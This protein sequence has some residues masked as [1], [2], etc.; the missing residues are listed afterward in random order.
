MPTRLHIFDFDGTLFRSPEKPE[1]WVR[2]WW[3]DPKSLA[4]PCVPER[5]GA[6]WWSASVVSAAK[7]S[8]A[9]RNALTALVT[10]RL[11][12]RFQDRVEELLGYAGLRFD[13]VRL[14]PG[15]GSTEGKKIRVFESLLTPEIVEVEM[16]EDRPEHVGIFSDFFSSKGVSVKMNLVQRVTNEPLCVPTEEIART[17]LRRLLPS[18]TEGT[19]E[20]DVLMRFLSKETKRLGV[21]QHVYVVGG[22]VRNFVM[23]LPPKDIDVVIDALALKGKNAEW[24]ANQLA[25]SIPAQ[26]V[27][28]VNQYGVAILTVKGQ[29]ELNGVDMQGQTIDIATAR[30]E[31]Y[32]GEAGKGYKPSDVSSASIEVDLSRREFTFNTL[33]WR[34]LDLESGPGKAEVIDLTGLGKKDLEQRLLRTP[35]DPDQTFS[36]DPTRMLRAI[37]FVAKYGFRIDD[38]VQTSIRKNADKLR[39]MPWNAVGVILVNDILKGP[40]PRKSVTL[41]HDLGLGDVL[42]TMLSDTPDFATMLSRSLKDVEI[43]LLLDLLDLGWAFSPMVGFLNPK[44]GLTKDEQRKLREVLLANA[45]SP[46]FEKVFLS[47]LD[48]PPANTMKLSNEFNLKPEERSQIVVLARQALLADPSLATKPAELDAAVMRRL[49]KTAAPE[50][51]VV[52]TTALRRLLVSQARG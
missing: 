36:D 19:D 15:G 18:L 47:A 21:A 7:K 26:T 45:D 31:S 12:A 37:K 13:T 3:S 9:D 5:P 42:K 23:G 16:W 43:E 50:E 41:M 27:I 6:D 11:A 35:L 30:K 52:H 29:W 4:P 33:M 25:R 24:L 22:A 28:T 8:I 46:E 39:Q 32:G 1:G 38:S 49:Q 34:L 40:A 20:A 10:G 48:K 17:A 51:Q 44:R 2:G 14:M